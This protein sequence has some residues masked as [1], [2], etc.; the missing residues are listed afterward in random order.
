MSNHKLWLG[1][2]SIG[3]L[4]IDEHLVGNGVQHQIKNLNIPNYQ[5]PYKWSAKNVSQLL[6]DIIDARSQNKEKYRV[7][8][9]ILH[10]NQIEDKTE[11][12]NHDI[13]DGQQRCISFSLILKAI[14]PQLSIAFLEQRLSSNPYN[15]KNIHQ[16]YLMIL[17]RVRQM[18]AIEIGE[19]L[20]F[21][22]TQCEMILV[23]TEDL[24]EAFQFFD[25]QNSRGKKLYPHDLLKAYHLREMN[26]LDPAE[27]ERTVKIWEDLPQYKLSVLFSEYLYRIKEWLQGN[28]AMELN[29][30]NLHKFK[31]VNSKDNF[32]FAQYYK[33]AYAFANNI[34]IS[35]LPFVT[36][37]KNLKPFQLHTPIVA[38]KP[39]FDY[40]KHYFDILTDIQNNDKYVGYFINDNPIVKTLDLRKNKNGVGNGIT[41]LLFD[42]AILLYVD[43]FCP[44]IPNNTDIKM[45]N[46]FVVYAFVWA[47][48]LRAQYVNLGWAS[49]QNYILEQGDLSNS[50]NIYKRIVESDTPL[51]LFGDL[52]QHLLSLNLSNIKAKESISSIDELDENNIPIKYLYHFK[53][54]NYLSGDEK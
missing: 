51:T 1:I 33:G 17:R 35:P 36:G 23:V 38:G 22:K 24:S 37:G 7:G 20:M 18:E 53:K 21:I 45:L 47:Y 3:D 19:L 52:S 16:N 41:R 26:Q 48:S 4:L 54:Y 15:Q 11:D 46:Q 9:L 44:S 13:V 12:F 43:R 39:F 29:E 2:S 6:D 49:A 42:T 32:P 5:R 31:G 27:I 40:T 25:S 14:D 50:I 34:N 28:K 30:T 10:K 8:T